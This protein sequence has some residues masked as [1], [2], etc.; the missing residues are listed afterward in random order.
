MLWL[1]VQFWKLV[2]SFGWALFHFNRWPK[3]WLGHRAKPE[4]ELVQEAEILL[5]AS[6]VAQWVMLLLAT[7]ASHNVKLV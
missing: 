3:L 6:I 7:Q 4:C 2:T 5:G 1:H